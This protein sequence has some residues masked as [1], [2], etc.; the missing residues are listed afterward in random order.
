MHPPGDRRSAPWRSPVRAGGTVGLSAVT[1]VLRLHCPGATWAL[2]P[3]QCGSC[4]REA[5]CCHCKD[6][7]IAWPRGAGPHR[8]AAVPPHAH[9]SARPAP[10]THPC[11]CVAP[12]AGLTGGRPGAPQ[13]TLLFEPA[14]R[15]PSAAALPEGRV[16]PCACGSL[17]PCGVSLQPASSAFL[18]YLHSH[19]NLL[20]KNV[21]AYETT[22]RNPPR[23]SI[24]L[25]SQSRASVWSSEQTCLFTDA[26]ARCLRRA[27]GAPGPVPG[28]EAAVVMEAGRPRPRPGPAATE[29][30][31]R[32]CAC[33][34]LLACALALCLPPGSHLLTLSGAFCPFSPEQN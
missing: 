33:T 30:P 13:R 3:F 24:T 11:A 28:A 4:D 22:P 34:A 16:C 18:F 9:P 15:R 32:P 2:S 26:L 7:K 10:Q 6:L 21:S 31:P 27:V 25:W 14:R 8:A 5:K 23:F 12:R 20:S 19:Q 17:Q 1:E 29:R